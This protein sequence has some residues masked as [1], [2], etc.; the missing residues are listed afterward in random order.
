MPQ[1]DMSRDV[2]RVQL[3]EHGTKVSTN[4][5]ANI[6]SVGQPSEGERQIIPVWG[7]AVDFVGV[8]KDR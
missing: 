4:N 8:S 3:V 2:D 7:L 1:Q 6:I 5:V